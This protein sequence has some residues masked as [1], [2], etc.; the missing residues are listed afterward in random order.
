MTKINDCSILINM[1]TP[2]RLT[3]SLIMIMF[4][5]YK[6]NEHRILFAAMAK[7]MHYALYL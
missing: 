5:F 2:K 4:V 1:L 3:L 7:S 6:K